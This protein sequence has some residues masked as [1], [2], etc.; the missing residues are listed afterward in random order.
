MS[1]K[2]LEILQRAQDWPEADQQ[3]LADFASDIEMRASGAYT[4]TSDELQALDEA[5]ASG[6]TT[7][8]RMQE[9]YKKFSSI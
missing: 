2:L 6:P 1:E 4:A 8:A 5:D 9:I 7:P 3:E